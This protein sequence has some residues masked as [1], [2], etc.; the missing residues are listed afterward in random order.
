MKRLLILGG[1][2]DA[3]KLATRINQ[4]P[5]LETIYSLAGRTQA[6][7][8]PLC[9]NRTGGFG[10]VS[11][12]AE[13]L[14]SAKINFV[15]DATHPF[16]EAMAAITAAAC[17][18][19]N[20]PRVKFC[21]M[22]WKPKVINWIS[23]P[24]YSEAAKKLRAAGKRIFLSIGTKN[25]HYFSMLSDKWFLI[26][27]IENPAHPIPLTDCKIL[28]ERGPFEEIKEHTLLNNYHIDVLVS[29]NSGGEQ[30]TK[31][32]AAHNLG[33]PILM[34]EQ[35]LPPSGKT[36]YTINETLTWLSDQM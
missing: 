8:I 26:R 16:A 21:R 32:R 30:A 2:G 33:I 10:G 7:H 3:A 25:L 28:L 29:K 19:T 6:P 15:I 34:I 27:V 24:N 17:I 31:L 11:G 23:V 1:T 36:V 9:K 18:Q 13:Y 14:K 5:Q 4:L 12:L 35:P 22:P 20:I